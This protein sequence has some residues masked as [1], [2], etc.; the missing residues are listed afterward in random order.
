MRSIVVVTLALLVVGCSAAGG[1]ASPSD[2]PSGSPSDSPSSVPW[3]SSSPGPAVGAIDHATGA[4]HVVLRFEEGGGFIAPSFLAT[5]APIFTLYGDGTVIF[6]NPL[7]DPLPAVGS[8]A[9]F[10]PFRTVRLSEDQIQKLLANALGPGGLGAARPDYRS[11]LI[12]DAPT[13]TFTIEAGGISKVVSVYALGIDTQGGPDVAARA[14]F[15]KLATSLQDF[16]NGGTVPTDAFAPERYRG[17]LLEGQPGDPG[18]L[19]WPWPS[20]A[21]T[22]FMPDPDPSAFQLP[23]RVLSVAEVE[24]LGVKPYQGGFQGVTL[25]GPR[26]GRIYTLSLRP[27]LPDESK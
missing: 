6:R 26:D 18:A 1:G 21:P 4:T 27:L 5:Q 11:D 23:K 19:P 20:V 22:D 16:D 25:L 14:A 10:R 3:P 13:A 15:A 8:V 17:I 12:A 9:P 2:P 24:A 7:L